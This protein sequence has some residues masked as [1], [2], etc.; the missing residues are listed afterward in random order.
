MS[1]NPYEALDLSPELG[2]EEITEHL[3]ELAEELPPEE[4]RRIQGY[5][6][7]LTLRRDDR[8]RHALM[9]RPRRAIAT[10]DQLRRRLPP[11]RS[12]PVPA[13]TDPRWLVVVP[14][15]SLARDAHDYTPDFWSLNDDPFF[16]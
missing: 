14:P 8:I 16:D 2:L 4:R 1:D 6:Q 11:A 15:P 9:A 12:R 7:A 10:L 5:W 13:L 3:R